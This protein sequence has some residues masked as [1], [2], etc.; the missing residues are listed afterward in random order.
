M[1]RSRSLRPRALALSALLLLL[2][3]ALGC[4]RAGAGRRS[5]APRLAGEWR[6]VLTSPGGELPFGLRLTGSGHHLRAVAENGAERAPFSAVEAA[7]DRLTLRIDWY[8]SRID[9]QIAPGGDRMTGVWTRTEPGGP[10]RMPFQAVR[11]KSPRFPPPTTPVGNRAALPATRDIGDIG[12][13]GN[14]GD[15]GGALGLRRLV[16]GVQGCGRRLAGPGRARPA[17]RTGDRHLPHPDGRLPLPRRELPGGSPPPL[18]LRRRPRLPVHRRGPERRH[19]PRRLLVAR[20][21][22]CHLDGAPG[23]GGPAGPPRRLVRGRPHQ[24]A[25]ALRLP[26]PRPRRPRGR[27]DRSALRRQGGPRQRLRLLVPELQRRG[28]APR[29]LVPALSR[30]RPGDRGARL[31]VHR[32]RRSRRPLRPPLRRPPRHH[33]SPPPRRHLRQEGRGEDPPRPHR[34]RRLPHQ[35]LPR[36]RRPGEK[37][38]HRLRRPRHRRAPSG[39]GRRVGEAAGEPPRGTSAAAG[40]AARAHAAG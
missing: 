9:A 10:A 32:R 16:G 4:G 14:V 11:G 8:D 2:G 35:H 3:A 12:D 5:A 24:P 15:I 37:D 13:I 28:A 21:L 40:A 38:L 22:P 17:G 7:G 33:L 29:R 1:N 6:A 19:A 27:L 31:R 18:D 23:G 25:G 20:L 30:P 36:P 39:A 26:L 34:R